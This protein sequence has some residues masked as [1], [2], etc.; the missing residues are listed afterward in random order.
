MGRAIVLF[1][2]F[3]IVISG[4]GGCQNSEKKEGILDK[5]FMGKRE[6][7]PVVVESAI[8]D[9]RTMTVSAV[10]SLSSSESVDVHMPIKGKIAAFNAELND[11]VEKGD[12]L[13]KIAEEEG[14]IKL[15]SLRAELSDAQAK[16]EKNSYYLRNRDRLFEEGRIDK[17]TY[18]NLESEVKSNEAKIEELQQRI[19][20]EEGSIAGSSV[21][22][23]ASGVVV[24]KDASTGSEIAKDKVV[25]KIAKL[26]P[27]NMSFKAM[28]KDV[29][30]LKAG[31][32]VNIFV[33]SLNGKMF[34]A[35]IASSK[36]NQDDGG[37]TSTIEGRIDNISG[38]LK[39]GMAATVEFSNP[40]KKRLFLIPPSALFKED[41]RH[42]V[43][44]VVDGKARK[45]PV[46]PASVGGNTAEITSGLS[47]GDIV[48]VSG[49]E[50]LQDGAQVDIWGK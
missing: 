46:V 47:E 24:L 44:R 1:F 9:E 20:D 35:D 25:M 11:L 14:K 34:V 48:V 36:E 2:L 22:S 29:A 40:E 50:N 12:V 7:V 15:A 27:V 8:L 37:L 41:R 42:Y 3:S 26:S 45:T 38:E 5:M 49:Q 31:S 19:K 6:S 33:Q 43:Y 17:T 18:D 4:C 16:L 28:T 32:K 13:F 21:S 23:P 30:N 10:V 39:P